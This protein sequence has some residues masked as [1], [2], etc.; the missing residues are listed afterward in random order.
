MRFGAC[1]DDPSGAE[2]LAGAADFVEIPGRDLVAATAAQLRHWTAALARFDVGPVCNRLL[3]YG[4]TL[5][6]TPD[7]RARRDPYW[8]ALLERGA[9]AGATGY[10]LGAGAARAVPASGPERDAAIAGVR[11]VVAELAQR[12]ADAGATL[13]LE[14][15]RPQECDWLTRAADG[16]AIGPAGVLGLCADI[17]HIDAEA[18][19]DGWPAATAW[20][21]SA[22]CHVSGPDHGPLA[23]HED[24]AMRFV[25]AVGRGVRVDAVAVEV[26]GGTAA[27]RRAELEALRLSRG[28]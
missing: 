10:C 13:Y 20:A 19:A 9:A 7:A 26:F 8:A 1:I 4:V 24:A 5:H 27:D 15:L 16:A 18:A 2:A 3:P 21:A 22:H 25:A 12:T 11:R 23:G 14:P 6:D 28:G 17:V